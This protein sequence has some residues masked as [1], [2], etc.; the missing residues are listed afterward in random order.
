MFVYAILVIS[1]GFVYA[2]D[3][4]EVKD[5]IEVSAWKIMDG[6]HGQVGNQE[7][8]SEKV[9]TSDLLKNADFVKDLFMHRSSGK[10]IR[11][12]GG[13]VSRTVVRISR[14]GKSFKLTNELGARGGAV[15]NVRADGLDATEVEDVD[16]EDI[17][18]TEND[19]ELSSYFTD[20]F[21]KDA[22]NDA[23]VVRVG[24]VGKG[25]VSVRH[26][27]QNIRV[28]ARGG[29]GIGSRTRFSKRGF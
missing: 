21:G 11:V 6:I 20:D 22:G 27:D 14:G 2:Q 25:G 3:V 29:F 28:R 5:D 17:M 19:A 18:K 9:A 8:Q 15:I 4:T 12:V 26:G 23:V 1:L 13:G 7:A 16:V 24:H 10:Q